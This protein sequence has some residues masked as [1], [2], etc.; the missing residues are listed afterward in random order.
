MYFFFSKVDSFSSIR[1]CRVIVISYIY[2][3]LT[4][5][6]KIIIYKINDNGGFVI[7]LGIVENILESDYSNISKEILYKLGHTFPDFVSMKTYLKE[8]N[9]K[10]IE[11]FLAQ[12]EKDHI[13]INSNYLNSLV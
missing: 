1:W 7:Y 11:I 6:T 5:I 8:F 12:Y 2:I 4:A 9:N 3:K 13:V 10:K